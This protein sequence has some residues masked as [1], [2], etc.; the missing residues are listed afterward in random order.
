MSD[1]L[2]SVRNLTK[3]FGTRTVVDRLSF[4]VQDG[5]VFGFLGHNGAG[6]TTTISM[7]TSLL[8]PTSG[9]IRIDG[10]EMVTHSLQ[11]RE[12]IGYLPE[13][14]RLYQDLTVDENLQFLGHL[15]GLKAP[16]ERID[17]VLDELR[18]TEWKH[19]RIG[20]LSKGMRQKVGIAQAILHNPRL[21]F[22]DEP[23]SG[24]DPQ[25]TKEIRELLLYMNRKYGTT[26]FMNTHMLSEVTQ[27][28]THIGIIRSGRMLYCGNLQ[29]ITSAFPSGTTL[30]DIYLQITNGDQRN[31]S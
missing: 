31:A 10:K 5:E 27:V 3:R 13:N 23:V 4:D 22:L 18:F 11:I 8:Q 30:E 21:L 2:L 25:G 20:Y 1:T 16:G 17:E 15:A 26:I 19:T 14:I 12:I 28:C 9:N 24:L 29:D 7:L 6:K